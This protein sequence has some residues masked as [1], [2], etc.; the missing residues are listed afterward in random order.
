[1]EARWEATPAPAGG[2]VYD[3]RPQLGT[4]SQR[5]AGQ[6][7]LIKSTWLRSAESVTGRYLDSLPMGWI[8]QVLQGLTAL[9]NFV[10]ACE[11]FMPRLSA[12]RV[13]DLF[14]MKNVDFTGA[15]QKQ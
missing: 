12:I 11:T 4:P 7:I 8:N 13:D 3:S 5:I 6:G 9:L 2:T 14:P 1:M 15:G 10:D